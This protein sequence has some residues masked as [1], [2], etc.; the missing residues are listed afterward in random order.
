M[1]GPGRRAAHKARTRAAIQQAALDL[2]SRQ[3]YH[4]TT[5]AQIAEAAQ[6]SHTT[7]F[8]Y[9]HSKEQ[10]LIGDG[11]DESRREMLAAIPPG[12]GHFDLARR[13]VTGI[14]SLARD[15]AFT[16]DPQRLHL[17]RTEPVLRM[18]NQL[19]AD[20]VIQEGIEFIADYTGTDP[21]ALSLR[22][23]AAAL[24]GV[25][26]HIAERATVP[27]QETLDELLTAIDLLERGLP[28]E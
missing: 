16:S 12:L 3:G 8:R 28:L 22:V 24:S 1:T 11:L 18:A 19:E 6:V 15:D 25:M 13:I 20:R 2:I 10:V 5:V 9:F 23:F 21:Q 27:D 4:A 7:L 17:V 14:F 26:M